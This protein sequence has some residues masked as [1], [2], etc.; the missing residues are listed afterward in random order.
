MYKAVFLTYNLMQGA[1][2]ANEIKTYLGKSA[3]LLYGND[4]RKSKN[5]PYPDKLHLI[6]SAFHQF[7]DIF[8][9][10]K[11]FIHRE[12]YIFDEQ[13][14]E[15]HFFIKYAPQ[16]LAHFEFDDKTI[17]EMKKIAWNHN[18]LVSYFRSLD[19]NVG[20]LDFFIQKNIG[21]PNFHKLFPSFVKKFDTVKSHTAK[22]I[23]KLEKKADLLFRGGW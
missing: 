18:H 8:S 22:E 1:P 23:K 19:N 3:K 10:G 16:V 7:R 2:T 17:D 12:L 6:E 14:N 9:S 13:I 21:D 4:Q 15:T 11:T 20:S 5:T